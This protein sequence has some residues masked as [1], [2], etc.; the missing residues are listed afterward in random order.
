MKKKK[1]KVRNTEREKMSKGERKKPG[2]SWNDGETRKRKNKVPIKYK[3]G[4][5]VHVS[6]LDSK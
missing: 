2:S 4:E 6:C 5:I 3:V 1:K